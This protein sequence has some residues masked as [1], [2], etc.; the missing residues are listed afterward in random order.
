M[1]NEYKIVLMLFAIAL[2]IRLLFVFASP[3]KIWDETVYANLGYGL[4]RNPFDYSFANN[5]WSDFV[6]GGWPKAGFRA[7]LLPYTLSVFYFFKFD[8]LV[9]FLVPLIGALSIIFIFILAKNMFDKKVALY[10]AAFL[11]F[12]PLHVYFSGKILTDVFSTFFVILAV[13]FFWRGFE[14][15]ETKSKLLFG[16]FL[17]LSILA[18]YTNLWLIPVFPFYLILKNRN[19]SFM[20]D[21]LVWL[22][23]VLF[24]TTLSPWFIYGT[25]TYGNPL[26]AFDHALTAASYWGGVQPWYFFFENAFFM[27]SILSIVFVIS[28]FYIISNKKTRKD[29]RIIFLLLWFLVIFASASIMPHKED[30]FLMSLTPP[31]VIISALFVGNLVK[32]KKMVFGLTVVLLALSSGWLLINVYRGSYTQVNRCF[33]ESNVFLNS[34]ENNSVVITDESSIVYYYSKKETHFYPRSF[35]LDSIR[36]LVDKNYRGRPTYILFSEYDMPLEKPENMKIKNVLD[37]NFEIVHKCPENR[38]LSLVY[39]YQ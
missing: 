13:I 17:A 31:L 14:R 11:S 9:E 2:A 10:S 4:S 33:L 15:K 18:R 21:R 38:N 37:S 28:L 8:L 30:R 12:L 3:V 1:K 23:I 25:L 29:H 6:P 26:G 20:K 19:L 16:I 22:M 34:V 27:F 32:Y 36:D 39:K 24:F 7:P 35:S 5:G